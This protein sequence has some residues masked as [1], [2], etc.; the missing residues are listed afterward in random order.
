ME[1]FNNGLAL[2]GNL[3]SINPGHI[4]M[5]NADGSSKTNSK[6]AS[7]NGEIT[8]NKAK[9]MKI[10]APLWQQYDDAGTNLDD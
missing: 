7:Q 3:E 1:S 9:F 6:G 10:G 8:L 4:V 2:Q 5:S